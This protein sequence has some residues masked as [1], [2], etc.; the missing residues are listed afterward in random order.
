V[1][2][3]FND[4]PTSSY[5]IRSDGGGIYHDGV[6]GVRAYI[7]RSE[8]VLHYFTM[9]G[10]QAPPRRELFL[11]FEQC[12]DECLPSD[13]VPPFGAPYPTP[14]FAVASLSAGVRTSSGDTVSG[15]LLGM[16]TGVEMRSGIHLN[17]PMDDD[18]AFWTVCMRAGPVEGF[19]A[20]SPQISPARVRRD[21]S[22]GVWT[23]WATA[24][25]I[26][27]LMNDRGSVRRT[28]M[29]DHLG[30]YRLPFSFTVTCV[31]AEDCPLPP[32]P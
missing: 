14:D 27:E 23:I 19:C 29:V 3:E 16:P 6:G 31:P 18:P 25:D 4:S 28:R 26:G 9:N 15:G 2:L 22:S 7:E 11:S 30:W 5:N 8:G 32:Q 13:F 20:N 1:K 12:V 17:I 24:D 10:P 21:S